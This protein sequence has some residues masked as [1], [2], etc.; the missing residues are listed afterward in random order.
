MYIWQFFCQIRDMCPWTLY[1]MPNNSNTML[2]PLF[3]VDFVSRFFYTSERCVN[4]VA[5]VHF[6]VCES[7]SG[8]ASNNNGMLNVLSKNITAPLCG[9]SFSEILVT[10]TILLTL[11]PRNIQKFYLKNVFK[12]Q[13]WYFF[14]F[15]PLIFFY[16]V[17]F[18]IPKLF[19]CRVIFVVVYAAGRGNRFFHTNVILL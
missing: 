17:M 4:C 12:A 10:S 14:V 18:W 13:F 3:W 2:L 1:T 9:G 16:S 15:F 11:S 19:Y 6:G 8:L 5:I 7:I